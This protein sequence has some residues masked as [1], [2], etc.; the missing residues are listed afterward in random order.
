MTFLFIF[1]IFIIGTLFWSF[2]SVIINR[3]KHKKSWIFTWRSECPKCKHILWAK[4]LIPIFSFLSTKW[5]CKYCKEK[6]SILYPILE[7]TMWVL[8]TITAYFL[9]DFQLIWNGNSIEIYK[10]FF[11]LLFTFFTFIYVVYDIL[12]LEIPESIL[13]I[14]ISLSF[15][16]ISL[17]S[18]FPEFQIIHILP[19]SW[20]VSL[21]IVYGLVI[22]WICM[23]GSFY[24]IMLQELKEIYDIWI[25]ILIISWIVFIKYY[26]WI[27]LEE[28]AIWNALLWSLVLFLFLFF[29]IIIS[30]GTW[31][32]GG[33]LR[34]WI[35]MGLIV[36]L[37]F[38]FQS[39]MVSYIC[40]SIIWIWL[41]VYHKIKEHYTI[42]KSILHKI[43]NKFWWKRE[44]TTLNTQIPFGPF[45]ALWIFFILFWWDIITH[46]IKNY[47]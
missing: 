46:V 10:L 33:D 18:I 32:W 37:Y 36:G 1:Y 5:K 35:L 44:K 31:M 43:K 12:Y 22:F 39:M 42:K 19:N 45:L 9:I 30:S 13:A 24:T 27:D 8:F 34:I 28:T 41:I 29:Q 20:N 21:S 11:Y 4:D 38:S 14:L 7:I 26:L 25:L 47:L 2:S 15:V 16:T 3:M 23:M 6:I 40:G 17:Q